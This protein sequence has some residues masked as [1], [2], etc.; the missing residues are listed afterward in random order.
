MDLLAKITGIKYQPLLCA[1][2]KEFD[3]SNL[4]EAFSS[5]A[6]F[7]LKI[8]N[9]NKIA[10]SWWVSPKRTRSYPY[11]RIYDTLN[12]TGKKITVI[13][14]IKDEGKEGDRDFLQW[15]TISLMSLLGIYVIIGYY[16]NAEKSKNYKHKITNQKFDLNYI[17]EKIRELIS[18]Q[19]DALH[20]N[21]YQT[22]NISDIAKKSL[23]NYKL[24]SKKTGVQMH[25]WLTAEKR[26][27]QLK[28]GKEDFMSFSRNLSKKAQIRESVTVQP[29][30]NISGS[31]GIITIKN[32]LGGFYYFTVDEVKIIKRTIYLIECKH[33]KRVFPSIEDIKDG[34]IKMVLFTNLKDVK[35]NGINMLPKPVLKLTTGV[36]L[37]I[38]NLSDS[39]IKY[40]KLLKQEARINNFEIQIL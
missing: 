11:A 4:D 19:S 17:K 29:K 5:H 9:E 2:L 24:I 26:I 36:R 40:L 3:L 14:I 30:E 22:D 37:D 25:S 21:L 6:S 32:Y 33:S 28:K 12:F 15:D 27:S 8:D 38:N 7:I 35:I 39:R 10:L 13:P 16:V 18:Y 23:D 20:W 31:K 1:D 34:L